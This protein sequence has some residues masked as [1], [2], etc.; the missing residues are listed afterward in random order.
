MVMKVKVGKLKN[1]LAIISLI[2]LF[3]L[4]PVYHDL[5]ARGLVSSVFGGWFG[6]WAFVVFFVFL[7]SSSQYF[8]TDLGSGRGFSVMVVIMIFYIF[9]ITVINAGFSSNPH[10]DKAVT[11]SLTTSFLWLALIFLAI[12]IPL[13][14]SALLSVLW[15][16][17][18]GATAFLLHFVITTGSLMYYPA[19]LFSVEQGVAS[20]QG[21][22]RSALVVAFFLLASSDSS[23]IRFLIGLLG[24]FVLFVLGARSEFFVF[25]L[26]FF[27]F[28]FLRTKLSFSYIW[29]WLVLIIGAV[30]SVTYFWQDFL[31]SRH[32]EIL[33][34]SESSSWAL[35]SEAFDRTIQAISENAFFGSFG[36]H[37]LPNGEAGLYAHNIFSAWQSYGLPG[38]LLI[39]TI[40]MWA[41]FGAFESVRR[42]RGKSII[43]NYAFLLN[44]CV[45][46]L[47]LV[48]KSVFWV[49]PGLAWGLY[50]A[51]E[52]QSS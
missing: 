4:F 13:D 11:Q 25:I 42:N 18:I 21:F 17:F 37:I 43:S 19:M 14:A 32:G 36:S 3:V 26:S 50:I 41:T 10:V 45:L 29:F 49:V 12:H 30:F 24:V 44:F 27:T 23:R 6:P 46:F 34:L 33:R 35:R 7:F 16:S 22:A 20:Y 51:M 5:V 40:C 31:S 28:E 48:S 52:R 38:F 47:L 39:L 2:V 15:I 8:L 9:L 1:T